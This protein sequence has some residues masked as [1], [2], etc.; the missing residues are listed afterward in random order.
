M[1][2]GPLRG[3]AVAGQ[4][5]VA[6]RAGTPTGL[7]GIQHDPEAQ[8]TRVQSPTILE[9]PRML[10]AWALATIPVTALLLLLGRALWS[11]MGLP[12]FP[13][14]EEEEEQEGADS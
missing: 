8:L 2:D 13:E 10:G 1:A 12:E 4:T 9:V 5:L 7:L 14:E 3:L 6:V 11:R